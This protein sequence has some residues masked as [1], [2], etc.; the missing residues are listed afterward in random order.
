MKKLLIHFGRFF[1]T[2]STTNIINLSGI[3]IGFLALF[4]V[5]L[6]LTNEATYDT[7]Y[8]KPEEIYRVEMYRKSGNSPFRHSSAAPLPLC[9]VMKEDIPEVKSATRFLWLLESWVFVK[10]DK[11]YESNNVCFADPTVF[12]V[13]DYK[14]VEGTLSSEALDEPNEIVLT[15]SLAHKFFGDE[16]A[17]GETLERNDKLFTVTGV[18]KDIPENSSLKFEALVS[19][20][21]PNW[22][23]NTHSYEWH[24]N[25]LTYVRLNPNSDKEALSNKLSEISNSNLDE[26][27]KENVI[28]IVFT[29]IRDVNL[30]QQNREIPYKASLSSEIKLLLLLACLILAITL[31]N[32]TNIIIAQILERKHF[33]GIHKLIGSDR[34]TLIRTFLFNYG[35][36][37]LSGILVAI[38]LVWLTLP[39]FNTHLNLHLA[40]SVLNL[41]N[42]LFGLLFAMGVF[43]LSSVY[44]LGQIIKLDP[45]IAVKETVQKVGGINIRKLLVGAQFFITFL[46][47]ALSFIIDRQSNYLINKEIGIATNNLLVIKLDNLDNKAF[48]NSAQTFKSELVR[49]TEVNAVSI[50]NGVPGEGYNGD[51]FWPETE[52]PENKFGMK[53]ICADH[54]YLE[55]MS[56]ELIA[57]ENFSKE[58][59]G[60]PKVMVITESTAKRAG[61]KTPEEAI[62]KR[63][64]KDH[65]HKYYTVIGVIKD[66]A[67]TS[68]EGDDNL[69]A[70]IF[71]QN[72]RTYV[73]IK[74]GGANH[75]AV[76]NK[77]EKLWKDFYGTKAFRYF[78]LDDT[79]QLQFTSEIQKARVINF[80]STIAILLSVIGLFGMA[81]FTILKREKE[82]CIRKINGAEISNILYI[83]F[84]EFTKLILVVCIAAI[85]VAYFLGNKV[86]EE[87][88]SRIKLSW[89]IFTIPLL[90]IIGIS[91]ISV[92]YHAIK[93]AY[94]N[95]SKILRDN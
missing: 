7:H 68:Y 23:Y 11:N 56:L 72:I 89:W 52:G 6:Y 13:F 60:R 31:I 3:V 40:L 66:F 77:I 2:H 1:R 49:L 51:I 55:V 29:P 82:F 92:S 62:G 76:L 30:Y 83:V 81:Y 17:L 22:L 41:K 24:K 42:T 50:N 39:F 75:L 79:Y 26:N 14:V 87:Y 84:N 15:E 47:V 20:T 27:H 38:A 58:L 21:T 67:L 19:S 48:R 4:L 70:L 80:F 44:P 16:N 37:Y 91:I 45:A 36:L 71:D 32:F 46:I 28:N 54:E 9:K 64:M 61:F 5:A 95:P 69:G 94:T 18:I 57:G 74:Y 85:P 35:L 86:L 63:F 65:L 25:V 8:N 33:Y 78:Y 43:V 73:N 53:F 90:L 10:G 12:D 88:A 93:L 59:R 34:A